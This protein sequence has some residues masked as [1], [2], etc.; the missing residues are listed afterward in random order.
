MMSNTSISYHPESIN[1]M[2]IICT[3]IIWSFLTPPTTDDPDQLQALTTQY[4]TMRTIFIALL[5]EHSVSYVIEYF[6]KWDIEQ[7]GQID[8]NGIKRARVESALSIGQYFF[9][10][11][12]CGYIVKEVFVHSNSN[13][14]LSLR[15]CQLWIIADSLIM[16]L[17]RITTT[18]SLMNMKKND[19]ANCIFTLYR[20]QWD[21]AFKDKTK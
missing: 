5:I 17:S 18:L 14:N 2:Q 11:F 16:L 13:S 19:I 20:V 21:E 12:A 8:I 7:N 9:I 4:F 10:C 15:L 1:E 3:A 6:R